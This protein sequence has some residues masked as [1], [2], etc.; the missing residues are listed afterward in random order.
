MVN[1]TEGIQLTPTKV[2]YEEG[3]GTLDIDWIYVINYECDIRI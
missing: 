2:E 3:R 1:M